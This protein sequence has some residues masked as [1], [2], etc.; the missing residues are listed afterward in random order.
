MFTHLFFVFVLIVLYICYGYGVDVYSVQVIYYSGCMFVL[1][2]AISYA[3]ASI[4]VFFRDLSQI[5]GVVLQVGMWATPIMWSY[6]MLPGNLQWILKLNPMFYV[7]EGYRN[8]LIYKTWFWDDFYGTAYF[9]LLTIGLL[10]L[11]TA[12]FNRLKVHFADVL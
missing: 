2:L 1:A 6:T 11:G 4:V 8:A 7:V 5:I 10:G 12:I 3:T 9:W